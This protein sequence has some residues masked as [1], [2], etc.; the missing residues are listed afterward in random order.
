MTLRVSAEAMGEIHAASAASAK[1]DESAEVRLRSLFRDH[2]DFIWR[3]LRRLGLDTGRAD[4]AA[5]QVFVTASRKLATI[6]LGGERGYLFGIALRVASD[7]RR[8][9]A[10][11][12]ERP[13]EH[14]GDA[15]DP[16]PLAEE[17][18]DQQRARALLD[19]ALDK[20]PLELRVVF[21]LHEFEELAM[22]EIAE[23]VGIP[24]GTVAS[25]L[26]R[27]RQEF[28]VIVARL[29]LGGAR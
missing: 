3:S 21:V 28:E 7:A 17:A 1:S 25:R 24:S 22:S 15:A 16:T 13:L 10:R 18:L 20:L 4:D 5:Q 29:N 12:R 8:A 14:A 27:A 11:R 23:V 9:S 26:R 6:R 2:Y 19:T